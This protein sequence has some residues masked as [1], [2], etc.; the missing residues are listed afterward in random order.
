M[1]KKL[2]GNSSMFTGIIF[3]I[4]SFA[5]PSGVLANHSKKVNNYFPT[6]Q[7]ITGKIIDDG[8]GIGLSGATV[9]VQGSNSTT[10]DAKGNYSIKVE[11]DNAVLIFSYVG[12]TSQ[13]IAV[14]G[15]TVI[16]V[17]LKT[18]STEL[19]QVVVGLYLTIELLTRISVENVT[20]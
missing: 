8:T 12:Y 3:M 5:G 15:K 9:L 11:N 6:A 16:N 4:L 20:T 18:S 1:R 17:A 19:S 7:I 14:N 2:N 13:E 10:S